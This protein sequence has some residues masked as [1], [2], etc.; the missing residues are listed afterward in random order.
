MCFFSLVNSS[1]YDTCTSRP[2]ETSHTIL[3]HLNYMSFTWQAQEQRPQQSIKS[4]RWLTL[5]VRAV[6]GGILMRQCIF[7]EL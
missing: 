5:T 4:T 2:Q 3:R 1:L 6:I 7:V